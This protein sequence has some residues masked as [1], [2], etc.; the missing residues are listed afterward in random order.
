MSRFPQLQL[1]QDLKHRSK[2]MATTQERFVFYYDY[3]CTILPLVFCAV[4][5]LDLSNGQ[6]KAIHLKT[7]QPDHFVMT[8]LVHRPSDR[9]EV[10]MVAGDEALTIFEDYESRPSFR[11]FIV[12]EKISFFKGN[13]ETREWDRERTFDPIIDAQDVLDY[14]AQALVDDGLKTW[15]ELLNPTL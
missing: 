14:L 4:A 11:F 2:S 6:R 10:D 5:P 7:Y 15:P 12:S 1:S 3:F 9:W 13:V 8:G